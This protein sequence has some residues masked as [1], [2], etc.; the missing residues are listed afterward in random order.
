[1]ILLYTTKFHIKAHKK[2]QYELKTLVQDALCTTKL[3]ARPDKAMV[4]N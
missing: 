4:N 2:Q 1:M 3:Q